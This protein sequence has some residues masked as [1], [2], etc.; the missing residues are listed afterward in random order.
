MPNVLCPGGGLLAF[1]ELGRDLLQSLLLCYIR[2]GS[3]FREDDATG[4]HSHERS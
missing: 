3:P 1:I 4:D 2:N